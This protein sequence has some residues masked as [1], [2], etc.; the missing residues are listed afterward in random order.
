MSSWQQTNASPPEPSGNAE[1]TPLYKNCLRCAAWIPLEGPQKC[2]ECREIDNLKMKMIY[3]KR[4]A[5]GKCKRCGRPVNGT[6]LHCEL[7][8][9]SDRLKYKYKATKSIKGAKCTLCKLNPVKDGLVICQDC[10]LNALERFQREQKEEESRLLENAGASSSGQHDE[11]R[12][13]EE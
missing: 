10:F 7:C 1:E 8:N 9:A 2:P 13:N 3:A 11:N 4:K 12:G 5:E 6:T